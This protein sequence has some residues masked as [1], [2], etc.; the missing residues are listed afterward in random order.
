MK[1]YFSFLVL[2]HLF[3]ELLQIIDKAFLLIGMP[4]LFLIPRFLISFIKEPHLTVWYVHNYAS[5][6]IHLLFSTK[7]QRFNVISIFVPKDLSSPA[8]VI[9]S[10][11]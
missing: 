5:Q 9:I 7:I 11:T 10:F 8:L 6:D 2:L 3:Q 4:L 1:F